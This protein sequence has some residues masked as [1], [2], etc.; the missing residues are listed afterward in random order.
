MEKIQESIQV[1]LEK[2]LQVH[3]TEGK[4]PE[5]PLLGLCL[6]SRVTLHS[7]SVFYHE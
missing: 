2:A 6:S 4:L 7:M 5:R 1:E 3:A